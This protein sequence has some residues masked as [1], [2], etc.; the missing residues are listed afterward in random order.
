ML[1]HRRGRFDEREIQVFIGLMGL[2][3]MARAHHYGLASQLLDKGG[4][5]TIVHGFGGPTARPLGLA[6]QIGAV[7]AGIGRNGFVQV[8]Q[9]QAARLVNFDGGER[10]FQQA[11]SSSGPT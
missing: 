4:L 1:Q 9:V 8:L 11:I 2:S 5:G 7:L 10:L 3:D 6:Y